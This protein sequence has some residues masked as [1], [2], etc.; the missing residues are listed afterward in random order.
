MQLQGNSKKQF[1]KLCKIHTWRCKISLWSMWLQGNR[2]R[3]FIKTCKIITW[4]CQVSLWSLLLHCNNQESFNKTYKIETQWHPLKFDIPISKLW[5][6]YSLSDYDLNLIRVKGH[7]RSSK[8]ISF[9]KYSKVVIWLTRLAWLARPPS[10]SRGDTR[11]PEPRR[12]SCYNCY[13][14]S[15]INH[16]MINTHHGGQQQTGDISSARRY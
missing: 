16:Y 1:I 7:I 12:H 15:G 2:K 5:S 10:R 9:T 6:I 4:R 11:A 8:I 3:I 13:I 14:I